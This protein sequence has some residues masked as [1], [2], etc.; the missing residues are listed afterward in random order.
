LRGVFVR[1]VHCTFP[2]N[3]VDELLLDFWTATAIRAAKRARASGNTGSGPPHL[4][5][6]AVK[7]PRLS[8]RTRPPP[9]RGGGRGH[10]FQEAAPA[11]V[12]GKLA[13]FWEFHKQVPPPRVGDPP[14]V[15]RPPGG[16]AGNTPKKKGKAGDSDVRPP[17]IETN[18]AKAA[19]QGFG[20][21]QCNGGD[22]RSFDHDVVSHSPPPTLP[23]STDHSLQGGPRHFLKTARG[24]RTVFG[25]QC[26]D[27]ARFR[28]SGGGR[29][30][31]CTTGRPA[32][33]PSSGPSV[34]HRPKQAVEANRRPASSN[35]VFKARA[36]T[37]RASR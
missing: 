32:R 26:R 2:K 12:G 20:I 24:M 34:S 15:R 6:S 33:F 22:L 17:R 18:S 23:S 5:D 8:R 16:P 1:I 31:C 10:R 36:I 7:H 3:M 37:V 9:H 25:A 27:P 30:V 14:H 11:F 28:G 29:S 21:R 19:G 4:R 35:P 13:L